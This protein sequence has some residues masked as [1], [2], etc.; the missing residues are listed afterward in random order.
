MGRNKHVSGCARRWVSSGT[1][2]SCPAF[3]RSFSTKPFL[4][5]SPLPVATYSS[6]TAAVL[7]LPSCPGTDSASWPE[8]R[9]VRL[10][11]VS[12]HPFPTQKLFMSIP[13]CSSTLRYSVEITCIGD[14]LLRQ[15]P[16]AGALLDSGWLVLEYGEISTRIN[17]IPTFPTT[18]IFK[19]SQSFQPPSN[20]Q[21]WP[22]F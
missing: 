3:S 12:L 19:F 9:G 13:S 4:Y 5:S 1:V 18:L 21:F 10:P 20:I 17:V 7:L 2:C 22:H 8:S 11:S 16:R 6:P 15:L 14:Y